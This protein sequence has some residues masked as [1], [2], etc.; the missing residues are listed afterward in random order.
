MPAKGVNGDDPATMVTS[1]LSAVASSASRS[2][3]EPHCA[4]LQVTVLD[5][6]PGLGAS[7]HGAGMLAPVTE[8]HYGE[9]DLLR[10]NLASATRYPSFVAELE[11]ASGTSVGYRATGTLAVAFDVDDKA[12]LDH[13]HD[14]Q[15]SLGLS[16]Q[17]VHRPRVPRARALPFNGC[18][19]RPAGRR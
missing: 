5:P 9:E 13:L 4:A 8:V 6:T 15:A 16:S 3:G 17:P 19:W 14:Y 10:L 12:A 18:S 2:P 1:S 7:H 11:D